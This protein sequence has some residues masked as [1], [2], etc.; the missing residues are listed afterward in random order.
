MCYPRACAGPWKSYPEEFGV[1][2]Q[3]GPVPH[4]PQLSETQSDDLSFSR[5]ELTEFVAAEETLVP[6]QL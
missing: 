1:W 6:V 2:V 4:V 5:V 3:S